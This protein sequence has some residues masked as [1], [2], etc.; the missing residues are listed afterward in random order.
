MHNLPLLDDLQLFCTAARRSSF[1]A[2][3]TE[4]GM[5]P[6]Y[7]SKRIA[8]LE[9]TLQTRLFHRTTRRVTIT[10]DGETVYQWAQRILDDVGRMT[11]AVA[12]IRTEPRGLLRISTSFGLGRN[13]VAPAISE[14]AKRYPALE[15]RLELVDRPVDLMSEGIDIDLRVGEV[16]E[17]HL[18]AHRIVSSNRILCATPAYLERK[19]YPK[20]LADLAQHACLVIRERDQAFGVWRLHGPHGLETVKVTGLLSCNNGDI[21]RQWALAGHGIM[22]RAVWDVATNL[23]AGE[24]VRVLPAYHQSADVW[25]VSTARLTSSAKVRVC[26]RFLQEQLTNGPFALVKAVGKRGG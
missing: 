12:S 11:E 23:D 1:I 20:T 2:T 26:V 6:T 7:V 22:L 17:P 5:S 25:A 3:A 15:V 9:R 21:V 16:Q 24:L 18:I 14:L 13:H 8:L 19:G 4:L 10:E